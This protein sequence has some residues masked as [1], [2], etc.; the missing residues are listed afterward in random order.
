M[1]SDR[2]FSFFLSHW[3]KY[4]A[5]V[6]RPSAPLVTYGGMSKEPV[7][8]PTSLLIFQDLQFRGFWMT[9]WYAACTTAERA[10]MVEDLLNLV[11]QGKFKEPFHERIAWHKLAE[12][13]DLKGASDKVV[14]AIVTAMNGMARKQVLVA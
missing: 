6:Y 5:S 14:G 7:T 8:V 10:A 13:G 11:R 12:D 3:L 4:L 9:R 1:L 2:E